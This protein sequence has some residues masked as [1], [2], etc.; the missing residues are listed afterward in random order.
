MIKAQSLEAT[1]PAIIIIYDV[2]M[3]LLEQDHQGE[4]GVRELYK[5][6]ENA[7]KHIKTLLLCYIQ[8]RYENATQLKFE[9]SNNE[10]SEMD[11]IPKANQHFFLIVQ[12]QYYNFR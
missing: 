12:T 2:Y 4:A 3:S 10:K 7:T 9:A 8:E 11:G 1:L 5:M 6:Y